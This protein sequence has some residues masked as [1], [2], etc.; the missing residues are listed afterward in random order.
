[1][2][3]FIHKLQNIINTTPLDDDLDVN[4]ARSLL[5]NMNQFKKST[6]L[7]EIAHMCY[8]SQSSVSRFVQR[9]DYD[10]FNDF[11][12]DFLETQSEFQ[13]MMID[14]NANE[15]LDFSKYVEE[16]NQS[17]LLMQRTFS[18]SQVDQLCKNIKEAKRIYIF[19]T[20]IP[21]NIALIL[22]HAI[23]TTGKF[24]EFY[25]RKEQQIRIANQVKP[26]DLC[27]FISLEGTLV[28]EKLITL[29]VI[30]S[31]A[32]TVLI[33]QNIHIK[34]SERF[35]HVIGLGEH[36]REQLGKY[37][38]L[39]FIDCLINHYYHNYI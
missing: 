1:M 30:I 23:L 4:I 10:N 34:F 24:V 17:L 26:E 37:K 22:Q 5:K 3:G 32:K 9:L 28:M 31:Q 29:P 33:T 21:G 15:E 13:E 39:I 7:Q 25:P 16:I 18:M 27:I 6:S 35:T 14:N 20:H 19:A 38:L 11:K 8:T 2:A 12:S 36:D